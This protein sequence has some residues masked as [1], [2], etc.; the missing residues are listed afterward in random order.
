VRVRRKAVIQQMNREADVP[1]VLSPKRV[2][3]YFNPLVVIEQAPADFRGKPGIIHDATLLS[4]L[5]LETILKI[6]IVYTIFTDRSISF[7]ITVEAE[8]WK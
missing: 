8:L 6:N 2:F 5:I 3:D 7:I 4:Q 1:F